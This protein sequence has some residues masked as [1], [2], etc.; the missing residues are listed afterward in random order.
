MLEIL[1]I[2]ASYLMGYNSY[3]L[4]SKFML[5]GE[6]AVKY[7][8][9]AHLTKWNAMVHTIFMP[10]SM[11]GMLLW[12]PAFFNL[13]PKMAKLL[14]YFIYYFYFGHYTKVNYVGAML[15]FIQYYV[16]VRFAIK[17]WTSRS[18]PTNLKMLTNGLTISTVGLGLQEVLG[19]WWGGDIPSRPEGIPN[20]MLYAMYFASTHFSKFR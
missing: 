3:D 10:A 16:S 5:V 19:H 1:T 20:A 9:E 4:L 2:L 7:Y 17:K 18:K 8:E 13:K 11:Y 6:K 12:I 14:I 15:Y